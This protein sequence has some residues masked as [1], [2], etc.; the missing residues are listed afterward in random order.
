M[1][2]SFI[3]LVLL[4]TFSC[5]KKEE[6]SGYNCVNGQCIATFD[7]PTY[8]TIQD[9]QTE[10][11]TDNP[12][13]TEKGY[14]YFKVT[15]D[16][17]CNKSLTWIDLGYSSNPVNLDNNIFIQKWSIGN[18]S[19]AWQASQKLES[20][21]YYY[22]AIKRNQVGDAQCLVTKTGSILVSTGKRTDITISF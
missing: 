17:V 13:P 20:G 16:L 11:S 5:D 7:N 1:R 9:C 2:I 22:K 6:K 12:V 8:L 19:P 4:I 10:C 14:I 15:F 3:F 18:S 21:T